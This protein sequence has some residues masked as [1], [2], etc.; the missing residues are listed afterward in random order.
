MYVFISISAG[1]RLV[2]ESAYLLLQVQYRVTN[3]MSTY[4]LLLVQYRF[5]NYMSTY[6]LLL[7]QYRVEIYLL[8]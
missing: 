1:E 4:L 6:L 8:K 3:Y 2:T 5:A 7:V